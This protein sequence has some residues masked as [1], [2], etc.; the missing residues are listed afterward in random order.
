MTFVE[1]MSHTILYSN[2]RGFMELI[3]NHLNGLIVDGRGFFL[4][5]ELQ[6][7]MDMYMSRV[8]YP[9]AYNR[10]PPKLRGYAMFLC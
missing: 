9:S 3:C 5:V 10:K 6:L 2:L 4:S 8:E 1:P 7:R